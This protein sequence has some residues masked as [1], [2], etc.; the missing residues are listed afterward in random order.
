MRALS[1]HHA[2]FL[3]GSATNESQS[4]R[5]ANRAP[6]EL[7][8]DVFE[9]RHRLAAERD[10]DIAK[11][12]SGP[13]GG[14]FGL[15]FEDQTFHGHL[16]NRVSCHRRRLR[17]SPGLHIAEQGEGPAVLLCHGFPESWY[18]WRH[19]LSALAAAGFHAVA[20]DMRGYGRSDRPAG[21]YTV[22]QLAMDLAALIE[23]LGMT[24]PVL[25]GHS[26]GCGVIWALIR[27][28]GP[29]YAAQII[30]DQAP[31]MLTE[32]SGVQGDHLGLGGLFTMESIRR[33]VAALRTALFKRLGFEQS[34][35]SHRGIKS[36]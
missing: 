11:D 15:H 5:F 30:I 9:P 1:D 36:I 4:Q 34:V 7:R 31:A 10:K 32:L 2:H 23:V 12:D 20:P 14:A 16:T 26:M 33:A 6:M 17:R 19:Q 3:H 35:R 21:G 27:L 29:R 13:V 8:V 28:F 18:S 25:L 24:R 22:L